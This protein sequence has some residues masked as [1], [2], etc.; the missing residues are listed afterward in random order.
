MWKWFDF[1]KS[2]I[3]K[4]SLNSFEKVQTLDFLGLTFSV[5]L[6]QIDVQLRIF[7]NIQIAKKRS[8]KCYK[9]GRLQF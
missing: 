8:K 6:W 7:L 2:D 3:V 9:K 5:A 1:V 4:L